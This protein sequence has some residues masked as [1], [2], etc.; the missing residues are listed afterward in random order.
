MELPVAVLG[1]VLEN[2][3]AR[4]WVF[5]AGSLAGALLLEYPG[6]GLLVDEQVLDFELIVVYFGLYAH[7]VDGF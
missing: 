4:E 5:E 2:D 3:A 1:Q 6:I 7:N